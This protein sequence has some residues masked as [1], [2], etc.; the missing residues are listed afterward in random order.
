MDKQHAIMQREGNHASYSQAEYKIYHSCPHKKLWLSGWIAIRTSCS[1]G[2][3]DNIQARES[4]HQVK[5]YIPVNPC[6]WDEQNNH[7]K[8]R[9]TMLSRARWSINIISMSMYSTNMA[10]KHRK[11]KI[12]NQ[13]N[14]SHNQHVKYLIQIYQWGMKK[15]AIS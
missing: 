13:D 2:D 5:W 10:M 9:M 7:G 4:T 3:Q 12:L 11:I 1:K 14:R 8:I 6:M 15:L